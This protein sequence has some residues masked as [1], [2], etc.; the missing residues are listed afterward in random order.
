MK[1]VQKIDSFRQTKPMNINVPDKLGKYELLECLGRGTCGVV[2]K[3]YD[4]VIAREVAIKISPSEDHSK[5]KDGKKLLAMQRAFLTEARA[6]SKLKHDNI[7][8]VYDAGEQGNLNYL[9]M[10]FIEGHSLKKHCKGGVLLPIHEALQIIIDCCSALEYSHQQQIIHRDI[11]PSNIMITPDHNVKLLDFGIAVSTQ[12]QN[13]RKKGPSLG[14][15]NYMSPEQILGVQIG[16]TS[17]L[18]SLATVLFEML[19][20]KQLFKGESIK[21]LF[22]KIVKDPVPSLQQ[23]SPDIPDFVSAIISKA[24]QK[25]PE[26]RYRSAAQFSAELK[27]ALYKIKQQNNPQKAKESSAEIDHFRYLNETDITQLTQHS[28]TITYQCG[29]T[30]LQEGHLNE[31]LYIIA[32][33]EVCI[34]RAGAFVEVLSLGDSFGEAG[35]IHPSESPESVEALNDVT[36]YRVDNELFESIPDEVQLQFYKEFSAKLARQLQNKNNTGLDYFFD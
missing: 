22:Q 2:H 9:V 27:K 28:P 19:T 3:G 14:T 26:A 23:I 16:I 24:L 36:V 21:E 33:G 4:P 18:Y 7:V 6:A 32:M 35:F 10:E 12:K 30:I 34:R 20:G 17:D 11:K 31:N 25:D 29:E 15:P 8:D 1:E 5:V 13:F